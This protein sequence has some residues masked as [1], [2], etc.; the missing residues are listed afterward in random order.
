MPTRRPRA[1]YR[2]RTVPHAG[3]SAMLA[4]ALLLASP[5]LALPDLVVDSITVTP[6]QPAVSTGT[7]QAVFTN[8][9]PDDVDLPITQYTNIEFWVDGILCDTGYLPDLAAGASTTK[10]STACNPAVPGTHAVTVVVDSDDDVTEVLEDNN[11]RTAD[12]TWRGPDLVLTSLALDPDPAPLGQGTLSVTLLNQGPVNTATMA[13]IGVVWSLDGVACD[14]DTVMG[15]AASAS[16]QLSTSSC[17]R[18]APGSGVVLV[19][20]DSDDDIDEED[21]TNNS[22]SQSFDWSAPDL[23][24][25]AMTSSPIAL[26][27]GSGTLTATVVNQGAFATGNVSIDIVWRLGGIVCDT[28]TIPSGLDV[29]SMDL[30][31]SVCNP[32]LP[33]SF[34][35]EVQLDVNDEVVETDED[36]NAFAQQMTWSSACD[37]GT[38]DCA[39]DATCAA[40]AGGFVCT[41][42]DGFTGD[43]FTCVPVAIPDAGP[44][45][46]DAGEDAGA[47]SADAAQGVDGGDDAGEVE[48]D[49]GAPDLDA[50][51]SQ[52][53]T[54]GQDGST[55]QD[56]GTAQDAAAALDGGVNPDA[57]A[58][59]DIGGALDSSVAPDGSALP[60]AGT[61][62]DHGEVDGGSVG[63][64][65]GG[66]VTGHDAGTAGEPTNGGCGCRSADAR[67]GV[68]ALAL[69]L[70]AAVTRRRRLSR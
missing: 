36:N 44:A 48:L 10:T 70:G 60:D 41:C 26:E 38:D 59:Q 34:E 30:Q 4:L 32:P 29:T 68:G 56:S 63:A 42:N 31:T 61:G 28:S 3:A 54:T 51:V 22:L 23:A 19:E 9:G 25:S 1:A 43:G 37:L 5:V 62:Q 35:V 40:I 12:I 69:L 65:S 39:V 33:G 50:A 2:S 53:G 45:A 66:H 24:V 15:L 67:S 7:L 27:N 64:D 21:E 55:A 18:T 6:E 46:E 16:V 20:V 47:A 14:T 57:G 49:A 11:Q 13:A 58:G 8:L 17:Y 52:D